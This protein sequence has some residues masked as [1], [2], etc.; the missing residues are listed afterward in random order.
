MK[1]NVT[2][3]DYAQKAQSITA[4]K[5]YFKSKLSAGDLSD[6]DK[7]KFT[8][9]LKDLD[10]FE[11]NGKC[12]QLAKQTIEKT[13][14]Q[15]YNL[16]RYGTTEPPPL[17]IGEA[18]TPERKDKAMWAKQASTA[19][20]ALR[21]KAGEVWAEATQAERKAAYDYTSGSGSYN[22]P[23]S[24]YQK[25]WAGSGSG[26]EE[27]FYKGEGNVWIDYE[28]KG[29]AI[30]KMTDLISRSTYDFDMWVQ[31]GCNYDAIE[32]LLK[33]P[34]GTLRNAK[35][36]KLK[37]FL[38]DEGI[39]YAFQSNG[40]TKGQGF[41]GEVILNVYVPSGTQVMYAEPWSAFSGGSAK[42]NWDEVVRDGKTPQSY[43]G[44]EDEVIIQRGAHYKVTKIEK[45]GN[46]MYMDL[47][48]HP[49]EGYALIQQD[50]NEWKGSKEDYGR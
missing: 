7:A 41:G 17:P 21:A 29:D 9:Y 39:N 11:L 43:F 23:L 4:K 31:R 13:D 26:F 24:G 42:L 40:A 25:P 36:S 27:K 3:A 12:Y 2:T 5:E 28:K 8:Q 37:D 34:L 10:E 30:R 14:K 46:K 50:P 47:D 20:K 15:L 35:P 1:D 38:G 33:K 48:V 16:K 44:S 45:V 32:R 49:E 22:R 18:F 6:A 19:D